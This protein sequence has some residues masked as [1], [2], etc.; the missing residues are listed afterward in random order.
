MIAFDV[1]TFLGSTA[2]GQFLLG[3]SSSELAWALR[4]S[5]TLELPIGESTNLFVQVQSYIVTGDSV[6]VLPSLA[7]GA[8]W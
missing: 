6:T 4:P 1:P 7:T 2:T 8:A 3:G 5:A